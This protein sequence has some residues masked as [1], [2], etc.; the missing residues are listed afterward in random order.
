MYN[1]T[2]PEGHMYPELLQQVDMNYMEPKDCLNTYILETL[3]DEKSYSKDELSQIFK[4]QNIPTIPERMKFCARG[5]MKGGDSCQVSSVYGL[6]ENDN[7]SFLG[8]FQFLVSRQEMGDEKREIDFLH[9]L[10]IFGQILV[11]FDDFL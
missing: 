3:V 1:G 4:Q 6:H 11:I 8:F 7:F 10:P 5:K 2:N 9:F